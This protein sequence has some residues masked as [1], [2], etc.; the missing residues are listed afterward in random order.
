MVLFCRPVSGPGPS[1]HRARHTLLANRLRECRLLRNTRLAG[2]ANALPIPRSILL[3][4]SASRR[5]KEGR[6]V[7]LWLT[8]KR[9]V[10]NVV[11]DPLSMNAI[12]FNNP[13]D[14]SLPTG[15]T[16]RRNCLSA[17]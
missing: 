14:V 15:V 10:I 6:V 2:A 12:A 1:V 13:L 3:L 11:L 4:A 17:D 8:A 9:L 16:P 5:W 7:M